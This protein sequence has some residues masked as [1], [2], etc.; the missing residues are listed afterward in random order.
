MANSIRWRLGSQLSSSLRPWHR[1]SVSINSVQQPQLGLTNFTGRGFPATFGILIA[2]LIVIVGIQLLALREQRQ[3]ARDA[4]N[5]E[6]LGT[7]SGVLKDVEYE[8]DKKN[9][10]VTTKDG[11]QDDIEKKVSI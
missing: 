6:A 2:A 9:P 5:K 10:A 4:E 1:H 3:K 11:E 8:S 7:E